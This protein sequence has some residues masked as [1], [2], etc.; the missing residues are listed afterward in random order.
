MSS[1]PA[2]RQRCWKDIKSGWGVNN[3]ANLCRQSDNVLSMVRSAMS[4]T[5]PSQDMFVSLIG[6]DW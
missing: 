2:V 5:L 3:V 6:I 4:R 1:V